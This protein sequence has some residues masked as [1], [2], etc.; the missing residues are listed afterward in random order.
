MGAL[1][2][3]RCAEPSD[4]L[5]GSLCRGS[6]AP[7]VQEDEDNSLDEDREDQEYRYPEYEEIQDMILAGGKCGIDNV[8][9]TCFLAAAIQCM[10]HTRPLTEYFLSHK[11]QEEL[12]LSNP[13][14]SKGQLANAYAG[15]LKNM[16]TAS[17]S[18]KQNGVSVSPKGFR[19]RLVKFA[20]QFGGFEQHDA[21]EFLAYLM[22]GLHEDLNRVQ[23]RPYVEIKDSDGR[24]DETVAA[25]SWHG[26]LRRNK[27]VV[28][29]LFQGQLKSTVM[30]RSCSYSN[31]KFDPFMYLSL[32]VH[33]G[34]EPFKDLHSCLQAFTWTEHLKGDECWRC[35]KCKAF[36][37]ADKKFDLWK[38]P[39]ILVVHLK[40]FKYNLA[41]DDKI[42]IQDTVAFPLEGWDL[43]H[44]F[45]YHRDLHKTPPVY[46]LYAV[47]NHHGSCSNGHYTSTT[48][49]MATR[50]WSSCD[51]ESV[52]AM[53]SAD[54][55]SENAYM[56]FYSLR[57]D[58]KV[59]RQS[60]TVP[61][62]WPHRMSCI[63]QDIKAQSLERK[64]L[65]KQKKEQKKEQQPL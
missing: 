30:C 19:K 40:R 4:Q 7:P 3:D 10:S 56:L 28:V 58:K 60:L 25:E 54:V 6:N 38:T 5:P 47:V 43:S 26:Y 15:L 41:F 8:G 53:D 11:F 22:D 52:E 51:D 48:R 17:F 36:V 16:W 62:L 64:R 18:S 33:S 42:K 44:Y 20:P 59:A 1:S 29:D 65:N 2:L 31:V 14:G 9:N 57:S 45:P 39:P 50:Q 21:H 13:L 61:Q 46:D 34:E 23:Q 27:S 24:P 63:P 32:P 55:V 37:E 35:P 49:N 12:N